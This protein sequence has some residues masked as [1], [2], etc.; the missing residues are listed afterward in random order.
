[1]RV[2]VGTL[3][4]VCGIVAAA[5]VF[6]RA[7]FQRQLLRVTALG[8]ALL[9]GTAWAGTASYY[10]DE[11]GRL[12]ETVAADG[13]SVFYSYDAVG[14][15]TTLK[16]ESATAVGI[17]GFSPAAG[18]V[19][20]SVTIFGS[21]FNL[22]AASNVVKFNGVSTS[23]T[24]AT[25]NTL[26][27]TVPTGANTGAI[28]VANGAVS[29]ISASSFTVAASGAPTITS[30]VPNIGAQ[31]TTVTISGTNFQLNT[32]SDKTLF[33]TVG[34]PVSAATA[35]SIT[36]SVPTS[37][38][39]G[40][41]SVTTPFGVATST[42]DFFGI[43][44]GF[45]TTDVEFTGRVAVAGTAMTASTTV[46]GKIG[47]ILFD[48]VVGTVNYL[49]LTNV[50][51]QGGTVSVFH[52][53]GSLLTSGPVGNGLIALPKLPLTGTYTVVCAPSAPTALTLAVK[54][55][56]VLNV[57]GQPMSISS[58]GPGYGTVAAFTATAGQN[59][60]LGL[61]GLAFNGAAAGYVSLG[62][63]TPD[64][65]VWQQLQ[66]INCFA[67]NPG[68]GCN[69]VL[70]KLPR[71]GTYLVYLANPNSPAITGGALTLSSDQTKTLT[72]GAAASLSLRQ[73][74]SGRLT[75]S[76]TA[77][78]PAAI[79]FENIT[80]TPA[81]QNVGVT[82]Y[83]PDGTVL[84]GPVNGLTT[85][86]G[87][88]LYVASLPSTGTYSVVAT[89]A[90]G[91]VTTMSL[92]WN[93]ASELVIDGAAVN[94]TSA[95]PGY[96]TSVSVNATAGQNLGLGLSGLAFTGAAP[97]YVSLSVNRPDGILLQ[98]INC[99]AT[100]PG[101]G[102]NL[103]LSNLPQT[104][105]Y[106]VYLVNPNSPAITGGALTLSS[107]QTKTLTAGTASS[108]SLRQG[109]SGRLTFAGTAGQPAAIRFE[110]IT[111]T[112][113]N[114]N[115][116]VTIYKPD[117]TVLTGPVNGLTTYNGNTL[118]VASLP[119]TGTYS[120]VATP[121]YGVVTTMSLTWNP[122]SELV[123]DGAAVNVTSAAP[124]YGTS[125]SVNATAGQ[126]LGLGLSG[127]AFTGAA[128]GY[129]SLSVNR[130]DGIL[131]QQIN[132]FATDPGSGCN[133]VL[134][135]LPQTGTYLVYL[136]NPN[137]PAIT[138]GALTLSSDQTKTLTAGTASSLSLRQGQSGRLTFA[139]TAGQPAAIRFEN[140]TTTP[141]NQN[142]GVTI[143]KPDGT[144][145]IGP[146]NGLTTYN[147][148][149]LY[150]A[151]LPSTGTY[152]VVA[153]PAYGVVTTMS[154]EPGLGAGH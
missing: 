14:N 76:G 153:T 125:V 61:S 3:A 87:N 152:S 78:Q 151:S 93:P 91:V 4:R 138:G 22:T 144:V 63:Y 72:A 66:Q 40:K 98:Q 25:A 95:A 104:G 128:P 90:Y 141:A 8:L 126:N 31:G 118:Y 88:T 26:V 115:V 55:A 77:G 109:Q 45:N 135:N 86:N 143:Y 102:C 121:A 41:I 6:I 13:T 19:G 139:G 34:A 70:S 96:G 103:V 127:L 75:F 83:K 46:S 105:T 123:I 44:N 10:Y 38:S 113:A 99:F 112:P 49:Q 5:G 117:G 59:L 85:Y 100:D 129:V 64:G 122:A 107:D 134:S 37:A 154:L 28:S 48:G 124:G 92:T 21:G 65:T 81:N 119:S 52:P 11:L 56:I 51:S 130:P 94:V 42:A 2:E 9:V 110:N 71:T 147:G 29:A 140:I 132:C 106:L 82:I 18:P 136:V 20:T 133:L 17:S 131:L 84:T 68:S 69:V 137:S 24:A 150:V 50:T 108:L 73:G 7:N 1:M 16:H 23:V 120:V 36:T 149:T 43:P 32:V 35:A 111:T 74:Q 58:V 15:I 116:G 57:D 54:Q 12:V 148:N 53:N 62:V 30:F 101:S 39:S 114:Q 145:L 67:T 33:G 79:R 27:V 80:T 146:V 89:P 60:G 47:L 97:G 142:V